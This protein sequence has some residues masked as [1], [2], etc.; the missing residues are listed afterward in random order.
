M[1]HPQ[2]SCRDI[3][4]ELQNTFPEEFDRTSSHKVR[5]NED[6]QFAFSYFY[7]LMGERRQMVVEEAFAELDTDGS[8]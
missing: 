2:S 4:T 7:F 6:M 8:G 3:M 5:S 1:L